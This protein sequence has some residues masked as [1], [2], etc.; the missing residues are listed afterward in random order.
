[1]RHEPPIPAPNQMVKVSV[2]VSDPDGVASVI[3]RWSANS[4][5][6][7]SAAMLPSNGST[8]SASIPGHPPSTVVQMHVTASDTS[9]ASSFFPAA[10]VHS[11]ALYMVNDGQANLALGHN[12]RIILTPADQSFFYAATNLMS[13]DPLPCTVVLN[14]REV[15]YNIGVRARGSMSG[16]GA[17]ARFGYAL[18]FPREQLFRGVH[19]SIHLDRSG[20]WRFGRQFGQEEILVS[21]VLNRAGGVP[22]RYE[23]LAR[24][25]APRASHT[26]SALLRMA[27]FSNLFFD[28]QYANGSDGTVYEYDLIYVPNGTAGGN[29]ENWKVPSPYHHVSVDGDYAPDLRSLGDDPEAYRFNFPIKNNRDR[30]DYSRLIEF[31][32]AFDLD[33]VALESETAVVMD[34]DQWLRLFAV[35]SLCGIGDVYTQGLNHNIG[36]YVRPEDQRVLALPWDWDFA[37]VQ[38]A[39]APLH[40]VGRNMGKVIALPNNRRRFYVHLNDLIQTIYNPGYMG[41]WT[42][43]YSSLLPGQDFS[44]ILDYISRRAN[45][46]MGQ[47]PAMVAFSITSNGGAGFST[48]EQYITIEGTA[49]VSA[50]LITVNGIACPTAWPKISEWQMRVPL[51]AGPN[52]FTFE[53]RDSSGN[54][55][56]AR[57]ISINFTG[58]N[59]HPEDHLVINEIMFNPAVANAEYVEI[60]NTSATHAFDMAG[61]RIQGID[62]TFKPGTVIEPSGYLVIAREQRAFAQAYGSMVPI[63]GIYNGRLSAQ[64]ERLRLVRQAAEAEDFLILDE[65]TYG[66]IPPWP[67]AANA[68]GFALQRIDPAYSGS[69]PGN[70]TVSAVRPATPGASNSVR[71]PFAPFSLEIITVSWTPAGFSLEWR[72]TPGASYHV[73]YR[74]NLLDGEWKQL[75]ATF[76]A[77]GD[78][79]S[80]VDT[81]PGAAERFY[82]ILCLPDPR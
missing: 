32:K 36:M 33:G 35:M 18:I 37:F 29:P 68:S 78:A 23:D 30:D 6:W 43:H 59:A 8:Y 27:R 77:T 28:E 74:D 58:S 2:D 31:C 48:L 7:S 25:I 17:D 40:G 82:R 3:L 10:G 9:G 14:E 42:D 71:V 12:L 49:P 15:F 20:G 16:R 63:A 38:A 57:S 46:V 54:I 65:V 26:G 4:G 55:S 21:H 22:T 41:Y 73:Q 19:K 52:N 5:G 45:F 60:H 34:V 72:S 50:H 53:A 51:R 62:F 13:N 61:C 69:H 81:T 76:I 56:G 47:L 44:G 79:L 80:I 67:P 11:R 75:G 1:L 66:V 24:L 64:G 39:S 70:W